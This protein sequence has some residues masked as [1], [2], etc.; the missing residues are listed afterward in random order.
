MARV[1]RMLVDLA[2]IVGLAAIAT[3]GWLALTVR[4]TPN[5]TTG[6]T[7]VILITVLLVCASVRVMFSSRVWRTSVLALVVA[8]ACLATLHA[9]SFALRLEMADHAEKDAFWAWFPVSVFALSAASLWLVRMSE[10]KRGWL[11]LGGRGVL[12][13]VLGGCFVYL[14][15]DE[16]PSPSVARNRTALAARWRDPETAALTLRYSTAP[17]GKRFLPPVHKL[18]F[19]HEGAARRE[20]LLKHRAE[21][22][23]NWAEMEEVR[24]WCAE[25]V[26]HA[27]LG[28]AAIVSF[29]QPI[30]KF[31]PLR[32]YMRHALAI[33]ALRAID[34][35]GDAALEE[36]LAV[37]ELGARL[38]PESS[39]LV[40]GMIAQVLKKEA[41]RT[42]G[43]ILDQA[44]VSATV[45]QRFAVVLAANAGNPDVARRLTLVESEFWTMDAMRH[46]GPAGACSEADRPWVIRMT[47]QCLSPLL[48]NPQASINRIHEYFE[49]SAACAGRRDIEAMTALD[50]RAWT[51]DVRIKNLQGIK[52]MEMIAGSLRSVAKNYWQIDD[53]RAALLARLGEFTVEP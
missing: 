19:H 26:S 16:A 18:E 7:G 2:L 30:M 29:D 23:A 17:D 40:R 45:R 44:K 15:W 13:A 41:I 42:A 37:Y 9:W 53:M 43:F 35:D 38:E 50:E 6:V 47:G 49:S 25:M 36:T 52:M 31:Q 11:T 8:G 22:M 1:G 27:R 34:Q 12:A 46:L 3:I 5:I 32:E 28:D 48:L 14:A 33:A 21:L 10:A 20:Y 4:H 51:K 39:T 24:A